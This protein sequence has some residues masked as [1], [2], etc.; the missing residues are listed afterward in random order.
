MTLQDMT[1]AMKCCIG[2]DGF[3]KVECSGCPHDVFC[4]D[5]IKLIFEHK[6]K[7]EDARLISHLSK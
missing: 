1:E 4:K 5:I 2:I 7:L 3:L 6:D